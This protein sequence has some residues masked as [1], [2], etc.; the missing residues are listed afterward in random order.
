AGLQNVL[1]VDYQ[2]VERLPEVLAAADVHVIALRR[3]LAHSSVPSKLYSVLAAG[4]AVLASVDG[5][6]EIA[7]VVSSQRAG[8]VVPPE[9]QEAF[10]AAVLRLV[11]SLKADRE[12]MGFAG[13]QFVLGWVSPERVAHAY[14]SLF[15]ELQKS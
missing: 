10:T 5:G 13:R 9:D 1:F 6:S 2:P 12:A 15:E 4:R 8:I 3:G 7:E 14:A 11:S